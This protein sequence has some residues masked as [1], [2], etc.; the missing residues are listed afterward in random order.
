MSDS[1]NTNYSPERRPGEFPAPRP[2]PMAAIGVRS[3]VWP[4]RD[5]VP[6][7]PPGPQG[8]EELAPITP[9]VGERRHR[10]LEGLVVG[11]ACRT[12]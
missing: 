9:S 11:N 3:N 10:I 4:S 2:V 7:Q 6:A 1:R 8:S 5:Q 12:C